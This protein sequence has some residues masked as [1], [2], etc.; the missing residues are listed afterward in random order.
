MRTNQIQ[1]SSAQCADNHQYQSSGIGW[2]P[3]LD[4]GCKCVEYF[5]H[6]VKVLRWTGEEQLSGGQDVV[7]RN[8]RL[9]QL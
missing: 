6:R 4:D 2:I 9:S 7:I 8:E 3:W 5:L 1:V